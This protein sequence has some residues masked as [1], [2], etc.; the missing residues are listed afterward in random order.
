MAW[1]Q[2]GTRKDRLPA[3]WARRRKTVLARCGH[4]CQATDDG[5]RC[6]AP[7]TD[8]DH[9]IRGDDHSLENLQGLCDWHHKRKTAAEANQAKKPRPPRNRRPEKHPGL[10]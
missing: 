2:T 6:T 8:V 4:R 1:S 3:D 10:L 9:V 7:A 5:V